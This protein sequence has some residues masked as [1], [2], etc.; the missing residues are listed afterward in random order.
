[1]VWPCL[2]VMKV[3]REGSSR[4]KKRWDGHVKEVDTDGLC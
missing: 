1:M 4:L 2:N 3:E